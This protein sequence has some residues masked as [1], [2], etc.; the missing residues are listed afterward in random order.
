MAKN[1]GKPRDV[2]ISKAMSWLLRHGAEKEGLPIRN[3]K[4]ID[5]SQLLFIS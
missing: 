3:G 2:Q 4:Q 5:H 1:L